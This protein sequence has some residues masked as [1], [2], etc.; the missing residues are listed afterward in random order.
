MITTFHTTGAIAGIAK[1][2][3]A[4]R[5]PTTSPLSPSS[6]T[7]GNITRDSP[8]VRSSSSALNLSPVIGGMT[9][10]AM[11]MKS[12]VIA[13][14]TTRISPNSAPASWKASLRF[15]CSS[16]SVK[17]GTNAAL[18]A[19]SATSARSRFGTWKAIVKAEKGPE[20][21]K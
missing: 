8:T 7:I 5:I 4:L 1:W 15:F 6:T 13:P 14:S 2:S 11:T 12:T 9:Y 16:S 3:Y 21:P 10:G 17:T 19:E 20:V 18:S